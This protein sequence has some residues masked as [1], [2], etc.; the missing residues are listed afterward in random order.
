MSSVKYVNIGVPQG[1][2]LGP[3]LFLI[4]S[5]DI[6]NH[7]HLASCNLFAD[8]VL[9]YCTGVNFNEVEQTLQMSLDSVKEWYDKNLLVVNCDKS[10][11]MLVAT[12]QRSLAY[13]DSELN[14]VIK[15]NTIIDVNCINYLGIKIDNN[16]CWSSQVD[17]LCKDLRS[18]IGLFSRLKQF[19]PYDSL[20]KLYYGIIQPKLDYGITIWGYT[21]QNNIYK[22]QHMQN[23][24]ARI[25]LGNYDYVNVRGL[26]LVHQLR[27]L[28]IIQRRDYF[29][30]VLMFKSIHGLVPEYLCNEITMQIEVSNRSTRSINANNVY[31]PHVNLEGTKRS[32][33]YAGALIWNGLPESLKVCYSLN[34]F[35]R[36]ARKHF[37]QKVY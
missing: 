31:V 11:T 27:W 33:S 26:E 5:N 37:Y 16:L 18:K 25:I 20:L 14:I 10:N 12:K 36:E 30:S 7:I 21:C 24:F 23:R 4:Y 8:D 13:P 19:L 32:F 6:N 22:I 34:S 35:K 15:D 3:V 1:S 17:S 29:M 28:N 9:I 2:I